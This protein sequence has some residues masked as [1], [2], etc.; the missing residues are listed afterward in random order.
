MTIET[1]APVDAGRLPLV[2]SMMALGAGV[3][4]SLGALTARLADD[5]DAWQYL[6]WRSVGIIAVIEVMAMRRRHGSGLVR[7]YTSGW[8]MVMAV[9]GLFTAS[10]CFVYAIKNTT[11]ANAA[12]LSSVTPLLAALLA[13]VV[14]GE[15]LSR[16]TVGAIG[17][18][19]VGLAVMLSADLGVGNMKGNVA[20]VGSSFGFALYTVCVRSDRRADWSPV[21][22]GYA[23]MM[24]VV[25]AVVSV[26]NGRT[27]V[28]PGDDIALALLH[29]AVLIVVGTLLFNEA[30]KHLPAVAMTVF[31][32]TETVFVP[33]WIFLW[34]S[35]RPR[36]TTLIGGAIILAAVLGKALIDARSTRAAEP[37][38]PGT[39]A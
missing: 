35:E 12:F 2:F 26:A 18:A 16:I 37:S 19:F 5:T 25:C 34:F 8:V 28:P 39:I 22:P 38:L 24:I 11:A 14:L 7:A 36:A 27:V 3:V 15:R 9:V 30:T 32:Q 13:R 20:A 4:W 23:L 33:M 1:S 31:A 10:L 17:L 21:L 29:G 6:L